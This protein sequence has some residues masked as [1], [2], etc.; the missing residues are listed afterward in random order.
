MQDGSIQ[1]VQNVNVIE[2]VQRCRYCGAPLAPAFYFCLYCATPYQSPDAVVPIVVRPTPSVE[3]RVKRFAPHVMT[4][5]W[6]YVVTI[7][8]AIVAAVALQDKPELGMYVG[9]GLLLIVTCFFAVR[10]WQ[11]LVVQLIRPGFL[12][13]EAWAALLVLPALIGVNWL[14]HGWLPRD[15]IRFDFDF[16][17]QVILICVLPAITEEIAFRGLVQHWLHVA[18][19]PVMAMVLASALFTALH[20]TLYSAPVLFSMGMLLAW[21]R[22]KTGSLYPGMLMHFLY[23]LAAILIFR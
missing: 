3:T 16:K 4:M 21:A 10:H 19:R 7:G 13:W 20:L 2:H 5:F 22:W 23:N 6:T 1:P 18:V 12:R 15:Q 14:W 9:S 11:S 17:A 8:V